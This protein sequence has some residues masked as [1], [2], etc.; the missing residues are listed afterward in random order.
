[1][2]KFRK[3]VEKMLLSATHRRE[4]RA[5]DTFGLSEESEEKMGKLKKRKRKNK[6]TI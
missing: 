5:S 2:K 1:L 6:W 4:N 3:I